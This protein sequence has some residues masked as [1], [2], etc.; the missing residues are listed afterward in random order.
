MGAGYQINLVE[1][2][3]Q[4]F[5]VNAQPLS[6]YPEIDVRDEAEPIASSLFGTPI[7]ETLSYLV[8]GENI[9]FGDS[10]I[11]TVNKVKNIVKTKVQGRSGTV[12]EFIS[13]GDY[14]VTIRGILSNDNSDDK[15]YDLISQLNNLANINEAIEIQSRFLNKLGI[16]S[17][18]IEQV[19]YM[20]SKYVNFQP[21][22]LIC[23]SDIPIELE[24]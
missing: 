9:Q 13:D 19:Q 18:V 10:P 6:K 4:V 14:N 24:L 8:N 1:L 11:I 20:N 22:Q 16:F 5:G 17:I 2:S 3:R 15:P 21:Y 23:S 12:K 7:F